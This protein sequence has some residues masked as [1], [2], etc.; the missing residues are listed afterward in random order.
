MSKIGIIGDMHMKPFLTYADNV[1][2]R[3]EGEV[4]EV[5]DFITKEF[6][7]CDSVVFMGDLLNARNNQSEVIRR[8]VSFLESFSGKE[9]FVIAGNHELS[10]DGSSAL[11]FLKEI[12]NPKWH[13]IT[14]KVEK[15]GNLVF[16]PYFK[17]PELEASSNEEGR[18]R[19]MAMLPEGDI[20]FVHHALSCS[21]TDSG[22][23]TDAFNEIVLQ[24]E[25]LK[26]KFKCIVAGHIHAPSIED[27][28]VITGSIFRNEMNEVPKRLWVVDSDTLGFT[29]QT[30][31]GRTLQK[32]ENPKPSALENFPNNSIFKIVLTDPDSKEEV[33]ELKRALK[34]FDGYILLEQYPNERKKVISESNLLEFNVEEMLE[35]YAIQKK[36]DPKKLLEAF[37]LI[38]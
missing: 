18:D 37:K 1:K 27:K 19:L 34:R 17:N 2:D 3:R 12:K 30:I 31:P 20:L 36:I 26:K 38:K 5:L 22:T 10:S 6:V 4:K 14:N 35:S 8:L 7:S 28:I 21:I 11:D 32:I 15:F 9:V 23:S 24:K 29:S 25:A 13:I 16:C 33:S